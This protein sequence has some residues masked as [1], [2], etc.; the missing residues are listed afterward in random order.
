MKN[1]EKLRKFLKSQKLDA[2]IVPSNDPHFSEYVAEYW[3]CREW[4]SGFTGSAATVAITKNEAALWTDSR[5]FLQAEEQLKGSGF[6]LKKMGLPET[7]NIIQW[8]HKNLATKAKIGIDEK[9]FSIIEFDDLQKQLQPMQLIPTAD[10]F[11][12]IWEDRPAMP[13]RKAFLLSK[14]FSGKTITEKIND[15]ENAIGEKEN[16][17]YIVSALDEIAWLFNLRGNDIDYNPTAIAYAAIDFPKLHLFIDNKKISSADRK[18]LTNEN[19]TLHDYLDF[20]QYLASINNKKTV[21][22]NPKKT[23][24]DIYNTLQKNKLKIKIEDN[25][26]GVIC[27]LKAI[28]NKTEISGFHQAASYDGIAFVKFLMWLEENLGKTKITELDVSAKLHHFRSQND[29]FTGE[30]FE[31]ISAYGAHG[32][33]VHYGA[34]KETNATLK[35]ESFLLLDSGGQYK[36]GTTDIT[37]TIH[38]GKPTAKEKTDYTFVLKGNIALSMVKFPKG[39]RGTQIDILARQSLW[40]IGKNYLHGTGHGVGHF[41]NVHEGP[42]SIRMNENPVAIEC[43]MITSNEPGVYITGE[44]GIRIENLILCQPYIK[45]NF[46]EFLEFETITLAPIDTKAIDK[47]L[48]APEEINWLNTYHKTVYEKLSPM[49]NK[50]EKSWLKEKTAKI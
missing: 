37:R 38:L 15:V 21:I 30:S 7:E 44:Y 13:E 23:S 9:L 20:T 3:K 43:G 34:T 18:K 4:L 32:A 31:T 10:P 33:I 5:Y 8:L 19:V 27:S 6:E 16:A 42:Q 11:I 41:L 14:T 29:F 1:I 35:K 28:K 36:N 46:G 26:N 40:R 12:E 39:T 50:K 45:T 22:I 17:I 48:L 47:K 25:V 24:I 2:F 49:L